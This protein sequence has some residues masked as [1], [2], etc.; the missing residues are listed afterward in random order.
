MKASTPAL[1]ALLASR[2]FVEADLWTITL[3]NG[4]AL[5]WSGADQAVTANG[6]VFALGPLIERGPISEKIGLEVAT[7]EVTID[8]GASDLI[9]GMALVPFIVARGLDGASLRLDRAFRPDWSSPVVGTVLRF[10]GRVTSIGEIAGSSAKI[11]ASSWLVLL[12]LNMPPHLYQAACIHNVYDTGCALNPANFSANGQVM[13]G[14]AGPPDTRPSQTTWLSS[15]NNQQD[16]FTQGRLTFTSGANAGQKRSVR[17][18]ASDGTFE[19][20][21]PLPYRPVAGDRFTAYWGCDR[22][23]ATCSGKFNNLVHFKGT[24]FVPAPETVL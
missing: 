6:H 19:I 17:A 12:N 8:A 5:R 3:A 7:I 24:E 18:N 4:D 13:P 2:Q 22:T 20:I 9:G 14:V 16:R 11:T 21:N 1:R 15:L 10:S 23:S